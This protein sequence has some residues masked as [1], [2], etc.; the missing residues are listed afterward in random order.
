[1]GLNAQKN[2]NNDKALDKIITTILA[3][4]NVCI[5]KGHIINGKPFWNDKL[6]TLKEEKDLARDRA[7]SSGLLEDCILLRKKQAIL[8]K[9]ILNA[10]RVS[11]NKFLEN[12]DYRKDGPK[13]FRFISALNGKQMQPY[14]QPMKVGGKILTSDLDIAKI[15]KYYRKK[16]DRLFSAPFSDEEFQRVL[17]KLSRGKS[18]RPDGILP[19]FILELGSKA[20]QTIFLFINK[21]W[22]GSFPSYWRKADVLPILRPKKDLTDIQSFRPI[23]LTCI[24]SKLSERIIVDRLQYYTTT[25]P[26]QLQTDCATYLR[27]SLDSRLTWTKHIAKVVESAT[28]RLSLLKRIAGVKWGSSQSVLTS[29]FT[30]YI[31][32][33]IDYGSELLVTASDSVL[34]K[35]DIVQNKAL[36]FITGAATL[37]PI[38][39][40][41]KFLVHLKD[42][43]T[44]CFLLRLANVFGVFD[45]RL[46]LFIP[47]IFPGHLGYA[48]ANLDLVLPVNKHNSLL[49]ELR[50]VALATIHER[51]PEQDWLHV[52]TDGSATAPFGRAGAG[53]LSD[54]FLLSL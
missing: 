17:Q 42:V 28:S 13:A 6:Q 37:T 23:S 8:K 20:K 47:T 52:C 54:T 24:L 12:F 43:N 31:R 33:V 21:T 36:R 26:G 4:A 1:M 5:P 7:D 29:T 41:L 3:S 25:T 22:G 49:A 38:N 19:E 51:Y 18:A 34:S 45:N 11:F 10:K 27:I 9:E 53:L 35:L 32:P 15:L 16:W 30:S 2:L 14:K 46:P 50:S 48:S 44:L 40:R 39:C